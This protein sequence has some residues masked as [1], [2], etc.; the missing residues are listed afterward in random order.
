MG[1]SV[2][3]KRHSNAAYFHFT[4]NFWVAASERARINAKTFERL[5]NNS[6]AGVFLCVCVCAD[7]LVGFQHD[8]IVLLG[9]R[10]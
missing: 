2:E 6:S 4:I 5:M 8:V 7:S 10:L 1:Q 9:C 3:N